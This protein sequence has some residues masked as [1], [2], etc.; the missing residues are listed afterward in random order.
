M[1]S[2]I[3]NKGRNWELEINIAAIKR[4]RDIL[5][6]DLLGTMSVD[7]SS[8]KQLTNLLIDPVLA[9]DII[10]VLIK[11]Q[12]EKHSPPV[13]DEDFGEAMLGEALHSAQ[14]ALIQEIINFIPSPDQRKATGEE[15]KNLLKVQK[16][17]MQAIVKR[18]TDPV[19]EQFMTE[20]MERLTSIDPKFLDEAREAV[21]ASM[22]SVGDS[23]A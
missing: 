22:N 6:Y 4:V 2:F 19:L 9:C 1:Q 8:V 14:Q 18:M 15:I 21:E 12:A 20:T 16:K 13:T 11:P 17:A 5:D 23:Q 7:D 3:D 10:F